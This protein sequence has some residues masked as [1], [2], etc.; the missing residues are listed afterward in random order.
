M[1]TVLQ[2][3]TLLVLTFALVSMWSAHVPVQAAPPKPDGT[4]SKESAIYLGAQGNLVQVKLGENNWLMQ[5]DPKVVVTYTGTAETDF[6]Q[7]AQAPLMVRFKAEIN[8]RLKKATEPVTEFE[9][10]NANDVNKPGAVLDGLGVGIGI[11]PEQPKGPLPESQ[12]YL[13]TGPVS[14]YKNDEL[15]VMGVKVPVDPTAKVTVNLT[16]RA[17]LL[18]T[19]LQ[20]NT[21]ISYKYYKQQPGR[22]MLTKMDTIGTEPLAAPKKPTPR[23]PP[24]A[25]TKGKEPEPQPE[26]VK[27]DDKAE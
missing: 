24:I 9:I 19:P 12:Q 5:L 18:V 8:T 16:G 17:A 20:A 15:T 3:P 7:L 6:L 4:G 14:G 11:A 1:C 26:E 10:I 13:I 21:I 25:N 27:P 23:T 2:R 22:G